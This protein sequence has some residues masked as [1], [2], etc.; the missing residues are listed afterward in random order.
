MICR[1]FEVGKGLRCGEG[2]LFFW[3]RVVEGVGMGGSGSLSANARVRKSG[4]GA[5]GF[6]LGELKT[7]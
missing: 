2:L 4:P 6:G 3:E 7:W 5:P 1:G